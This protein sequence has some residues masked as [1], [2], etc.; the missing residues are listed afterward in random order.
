MM[1]R[2]QIWLA[3]VVL[4]GLG[5]FVSRVS[6]TEVEEK[7][8][9]EEIL[10]TGR[11]WTVDWTVGTI[12]Y[13]LQLTLNGKATDTI[14]ELTGDGTIRVKDKTVRIHVSVQLT[15][16]KF[17]YVTRYPAMTF[18]FQ[19]RMTS[20]DP[21]VFPVKETIQMTESLLLKE[22]NLC[23][24]SQRQNPQCLKPQQK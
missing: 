20:S 10:N 4:F 22:G 12:Q 15:Q 11:N 6:A 1:H 8:A 16:G 14:G 2:S 24:L 19:G 17:H 7:K 23:P 18:T 21:S 9:Q 13:K 3:V 5:L